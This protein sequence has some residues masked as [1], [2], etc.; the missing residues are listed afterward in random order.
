MADEGTSEQARRISAL[1]DAVEEG[2]DG[3]LD[4]LVAE[5]YPDLKKLAHFQLAGERRGH[6]L[7]TTAIV[8]EAFLRLAGG[9]NRYSDRAHFLRA[10][11]KVMR[12]LLVDYAR[13]RNAEKRGAGADPL[14]LQD[15]RLGLAD[16]T[17]AVLAMNAA[18]QEISAIDP[19]LEQV[20]ECRYF[21]GLSVQDTADAL[22]MSVRS[23]ERASQRARAYLVN[24]METGTD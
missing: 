4:A 2:A 15:D 19:A 6:T 8:H 22:D 21:A 13:R 17:I 24:A 7:N 3:A 20:I 10:A 16:D 18:M 5:I 23:V 14:T 9:S 1:L 12:H 11:A